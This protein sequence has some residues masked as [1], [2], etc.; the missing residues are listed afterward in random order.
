[1]AEKTSLLQIRVAEHPLY[2][3][4]VHSVL[5][6]P[7]PPNNPASVRMVNEL[8]AWELSGADLPPHFGAW[9]IGSRAPAY[10]SFMP[11]QYCLPG[12]LQN[13]PVERS[14]ALQLRIVSPTENDH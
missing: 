5:E 9:C 10:V 1:M 3:K 7:F 4:G 11:T 6:L 13:L 2:V 14:S 8:N 12:L